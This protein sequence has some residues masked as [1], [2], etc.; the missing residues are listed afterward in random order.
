MLHH[1]PNLPALTLLVS[2]PSS[3][4]LIQPFRASAQSQTLP[5]I[6]TGSRGVNEIINP[7]LFSQRA[8]VE[9]VTWERVSLTDR[10][11][12]NVQNASVFFQLTT[13]NS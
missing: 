3:I 9:H 7:I 1:F 12:N 6:T 2:R 4:S 10:D 13:A 5:Q 8:F 11:G